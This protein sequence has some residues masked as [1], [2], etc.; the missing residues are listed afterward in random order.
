MALSD[1]VLSAAF[2]ARVMAALLKTSTSKNQ[3]TSQIAGAHRAWWL[4]LG[5]HVAMHSKTGYRSVDR[6]Y[7]ACNGK[8]FCDKKLTTNQ[9]SLL[10]ALNI[11]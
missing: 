2:L 4:V 7:N 6:G 8:G 3:T 1:S 5:V 10:S 11:G 9:L